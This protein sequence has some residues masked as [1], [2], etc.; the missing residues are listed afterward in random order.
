MLLHY[1]EK[2]WHWNYVIADVTAVVVN[3]VFSDKDKILIKHL[4]AEGI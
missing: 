2:L 4:S 3:V 1:L